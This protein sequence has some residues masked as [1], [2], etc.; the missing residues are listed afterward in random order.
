M[1]LD[2]ILR[3]TGHDVWFRPTSGGSVGRL[4]VTR[5]R[6]QANHDAAILRQ[7]RNVVERFTN[8]STRRHQFSIQL[9][10]VRRPNWR[11]ASLAAL[12]PIDVQT[13]GIEAWTLAREEAT[14][15]TARLRQRNDY[16]ELARHDEIRNGGEF[17]W[18]QRQPR[19][20]PRTLALDPQRWPGYQTLFGQI[21]EGMHL[22]VFP[23]TMPN[24]RESEVV[25]KGEAE[26]VEQ[27]HDVWSNVTTPGTPQRTRTQVPQVC[28]WRMHERFRW[29]ADRVLLVSRGIVALP[30][31]PSSGAALPFA[32]VLGARPARGELLVFV[33]DAGRREAIAPASP[34]AAAP[35]SE[36]TAARSAALPN[37]NRVNTRGRY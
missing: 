31:A 27:F 32:D 9:V 25:I 17:L 19:N 10:A 36:G 20:Y 35:P 11:T 30:G 1:W 12:Q 34:N 15:L 13:P 28:G 23:L 5:D 16:L 26:Q 22:S 29:P 24:E 4:V 33:A 8:P 6:V 18:E 14:M 2:W 37:S 21:S 7:V 3:D